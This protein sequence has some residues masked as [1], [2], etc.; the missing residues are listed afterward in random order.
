MNETTITMF[1]ED[2]IK[3]IPFKP[4][5]PENKNKDITKEW[6]KKVVKRT[7]RLE[8]AYSFKLKPHRNVL[9][10]VPGQRPRGK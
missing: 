10:L 7:R 2:G 4:G 5:N 6:K 9:E 3:T 8:N 1:S